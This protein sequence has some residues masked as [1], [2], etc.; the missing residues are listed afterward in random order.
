MFEYDCIVVPG[1]GGFVTYTEHASIVFDKNLILPPFKRLSFNINLS[2]ND[3]LLAQ[4]TV[5]KCGISYEDALKSISDLANQ[6]NLV[7]EQNKFLEL[8]FIGTF[9]KTKE[10]NLL[11]D[12][13]AEE[14]YS[15]DS[16]GLSPIHAIVIEKDGISGKI[17]KEL[18]QRKS[19]PNFNK[20]V[21]KYTIVSSLSL[22]LVS[23]II[24]T[25]LNLNLINDKA[26]R[27][28]LFFWNNSTVKTT[29]VEVNSK[30]LPTKSK[31]ESLEDKIGIDSE[32]D[33]TQD[34]PFD[35]LNNSISE[36]STQEKPIDSKAQKNI[37]S[38]NI[39]SSSN[40]LKTS[41]NK[42]IIVAGCFQSQQNAQNFVKYLKDLGYNASIVGLSDAGLHR[43]AYDS[44]S[45]KEAAME[46]LSNIRL[47]HNSSAWICSM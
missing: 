33:K 23:L 6:W 15:A 12:Q 34:L 18:V 2:K 4:E 35:S 24:W 27:L 9:R 41:L 45:T 31:K 14:N 40:S 16:F 30:P 47:E 21:R 3:G 42:F 28:D 7:L 39:P 29:E 10:G 20:K 19:A 1:F 5:L 44:F 46:K 26:S 17:K 38:E 25:G 22:A 8:N 11:F 36:V 32:S 13:A 43:V 37:S